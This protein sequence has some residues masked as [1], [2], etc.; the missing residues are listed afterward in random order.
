M[1][2]ALQRQLVTTGWHLLGGAIALLLL[3]I[4]VGIWGSHIEDRIDKGEAA[5]VSDHRAIGRISQALHHAHIALP[6]RQETS[7]SGGGEALQP[8]GSSGHQQ[9]GPSSGGQGKSG[10]DGGHSG[11]HSQGQNPGSKSPAPTPEANPAPAA[12]D[13]GADITT[14]TTP[15]EEHADHP[16]PA[17]VEATGKAAGEVVGQS[18]G[19]V[20]GTVEGAGAAVCRVAATPGCSK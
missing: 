4:G 11:G 17:T 13:T 1:K 9:P 20:Q 19:A 7:S 10:H 6:A 15:A 14:P 18:G 8:G 16:L 3:F 12:R 5:H 2:T